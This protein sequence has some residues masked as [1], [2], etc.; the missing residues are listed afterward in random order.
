MGNSFL[1]VYHMFSKDSWGV[2]RERFI[3]VLDA[4]VILCKLILMHEKAEIE[5]VHCDPDTFV[6]KFMGGS[7]PPQKKQ[8]ST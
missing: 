1:N 2:R 5:L 8:N 4:Y 6:L 3:R 7:P